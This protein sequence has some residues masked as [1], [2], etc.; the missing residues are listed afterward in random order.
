VNGHVPGTPAA[1]MLLV[2]T[3]ELVDPNFDHT[4]VLLLDADADGAVGVV[5]N[6]PSQ[7]SVSEILPPWGEVVTGPD[8]VFHGGPV[9]TDSALAVATLPT[10]DVARSATEGEGEEP[11]AERG[12]AIDATGGAGPWTEAADPVGFRRVFGDTGIVDLDVPTEL[13]APALRGM[14]VFA[15]Y[16][17]WGAGQVEAEIEEGSWYVVP[18]LAE[19]LLGARPEQLWTQVL[20]RQPGALAWV[21]TRPVNPQLN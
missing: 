14:R 15:G 5:L 12:A 17:G 3:P 1:G 2:A 10:R 8:V 21:S 18:A 11:D 16:A 4:V 19:D 7:V 13:L 20:K 9:G 6:R